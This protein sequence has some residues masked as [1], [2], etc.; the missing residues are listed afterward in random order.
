MVFLTLLNTSVNCCSI[1]FS[2]KTLPI[3]GHA[4][5]I[6]ARAL[7]IHARALPICAHALPIRARAL[8]IHAHAHTCI[9]RFKL[10]ICEHI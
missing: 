1:K 9:K 6:H 8:P 2:I 7:P 10:P 5:P 4:L 3:R